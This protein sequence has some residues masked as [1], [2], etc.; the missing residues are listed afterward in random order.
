MPIC[1]ETERDPPMNRSHVDQL[2]PK[3][4]LYSDI[5][6][7]PN[8]SMTQVDSLGIPLIKNLPNCIIIIL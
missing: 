3:G 1:M 5:I 2:G 6:I 8:N 4:N 7:L